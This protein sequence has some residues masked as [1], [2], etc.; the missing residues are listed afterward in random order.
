[1]PTE[2]IHQFQSLSHNIEAIDNAEIEKKKSIILS[3]NDL[4]FSKTFVVLFV[5]GVSLFLTTSV[6]RWL[7]GEVRV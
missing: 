7:R 2:A 1:M 3:L 4:L 6:E 5:P